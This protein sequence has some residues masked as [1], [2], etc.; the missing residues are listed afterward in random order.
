M[1]ESLSKEF[2]SG[3]FRNLIIGLLGLLNNPKAFLEAQK[4]LYQ[5]RSMF[6][7]PHSDLNSHTGLPNP[8][9]QYYCN[10][11]TVC[12]SQEGRL[13]RILNI[14]SG[15]DPGKKL[16]AINVDISPAG[17]PDVI[18]DSRHLPFKDNVFTVVR[19]SHVLEHFD[20]NEIPSVLE[21]W[22]RVLH[23]FG[24]LHI[25]VPDAKITFE[26]IE[27]GTTPKGLPSFSLETS[28]APLAQIY[29]LGYENPNTDARWLHR[30]IFSEALLN[31][32]LNEMGFP[33]T[34]K[35]ERTDDLAYLCGVDDDSQ[36]HYS[37]LIAARK[38]IPEHKVEPILPQNIF[39]QK[40]RDFRRQFNQPPPVSFIIPVCNEERN[41]PIFLSFLVAAE[42]QLGGRR[43]FIFV[44]NNTTDK[45]REIIRY[46]QENTDLD[47]C[48]VDST[49][50][51]IIRAFKK[52][53]ENRRLEDS[54][55]GKLDADIIIHPH[56]LDLMTMY[57]VENP[58]LEVTYSE[59]Q[60]IDSICEYNQP[61]HG[62]IRRTK[63]LY[64][65]GRASLYRHNPFN[66]LEECLPNIMEL[67]INS[68]QVED[69]LFSFLYTFFF[70]LDSIRVTPHSVIYGRTVQS[71]EDLKT[72]INRCAKEMATIFSIYPPFAI[73][74]KLLERRI[75][76]NVDY[77]DLLLRIQ[78]EV[79]KRAH[80]SEWTRLSCH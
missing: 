69:I 74:E 39:L 51:G 72:Q 9:S 44:V 48:L 52:G 31:F 50:P 26:E 11:S 53:I 17:E 61:E 46:W 64:I 38:E 19:A 28:T 30:I 2:S 55:I 80:N 58:S 8:A 71:F 37:L 54:L 40:V 4:E 60:P 15:P 14:G 5:I 35:R 27:S 16:A 76:D 77:K 70:G 23:P 78:G 7:N 79:E 59:P 36:N 49:E 20:Q 63:R 33:E 41:L 65:H 13:P 68:L 18:A 32:F 62:K 22:E 73:I 1:S 75:I 25:A 24:E 10:G 66:Q 21:E 34:R 3:D 67:F 47:I 56:A 29:G 12:R 42:N 45:S 57:L 43:E 6:Y